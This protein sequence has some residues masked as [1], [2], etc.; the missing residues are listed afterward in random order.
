MYIS[1]FFSFISFPVSS[2]SIIQQ[3]KQDMYV[4]HT[5]VSSPC[6][7]SISI[8]ITNGV[9]HIVQS[10]FNLTLYTAAQRSVVLKHICMCVIDQRSL[11]SRYMCVHMEPQRHCKYILHEYEVITHKLLPLVSHYI[12]SL[13][14]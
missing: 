1:Y 11:Y 14:V 9:C 6:V 2:V 3:L 4:V 8:V 7:P 5:Y 10:H 12:C 13:E